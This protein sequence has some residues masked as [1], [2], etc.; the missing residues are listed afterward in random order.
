MCRDI[1]ARLQFQEGWH[2]LVTP[3][4]MG[5]PP[6]PTGVSNDP[7]TSMGKRPFPTSLSLTCSDVLDFG[8]I[9][10]GYSYGVEV[11]AEVPVD[12][13]R[14]PTQVVIRL[15]NS[16]CVLVHALDKPAPHQCKI[17]VVVTATEAGAVTGAIYVDPTSR[18]S[19]FSLKSSSSAFCCA[20][21]SACEQRFSQLSTSIPPSRKDRAP[22]VPTCLA[23][24]TSAAGAGDGR[25]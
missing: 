13:E 12:V 15:S 20:Y 14:V 17:Q 19:L 5:E 7:T 3:T 1:T 9:K 11:T 25:C 4:R 10:L 23:S 16:P 8:H 6:I 2:Q 21:F 22:A 24:G 18:G